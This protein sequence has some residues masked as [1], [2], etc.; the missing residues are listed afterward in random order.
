MDATQPY[1]AAVP[2]YVSLLRAVNVGGRK[3]AM[4]AL[5]ELYERLGHADVVTYVQS[6]NV[7]SR[8]S[9]RRA[10]TV[11][12]TLG[13]AITAEFGI[14]VDVLVRTPGQLRTVLDANP[15]LRAR[16]APP[17][18][19]SLKSLHV[20]FLAREPEPARGRDLDG[21]AFAPDEFRIV[22]REVFLTCPGGYGHTKITNSWFERKLGVPATTRN[23]ATVTKLGELCGA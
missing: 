20:T 1:S 22:G 9:A 12:E 8:T 19:K 2:V 18:E 15:F 23:W 14:E 7:V 5:R 10:A 3:V 13:A 4:A 11:E 17:H 16:G 21:S 6:G